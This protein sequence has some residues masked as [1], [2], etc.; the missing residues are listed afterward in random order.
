MT[1]IYEQAL[2]RDFGRL[3]PRMRERFGLCSADGIANI[4]TGTMDRVERGSTLTVP[5]LRLGATRNLLFPD[6]GRAIPFTVANYAYRDP[7]GRETVTWHRTFNFQRRRRVFAAAMVYSPRRRT[8]V[9]YLGSHHHVATDLG[10]W[11]DDEGGMN[12]TSGEFRFFEGPIRCRLPRWSAGS[13]R[14][15][16]WWDDGLGKYRITVRITNPVLGPVLGYR[17][18][19]T[20]HQ[21]PVRR[22][23]DIP[24]E[25]LP[26]RPTPGPE[27]SG[28]SRAVPRAASPV[29]GSR[30]IAG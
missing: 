29:G 2:G 16:E 20:N 27:R 7:F 4:G 30:R 13:A 18:T 26:R 24:R 9:D 23:T 10:C 21:V 28:V 15:R 17:G 14:V 1:S 25:V 12:F 3:H 5:F 6:Q 22:P 11:V 19:F 8:I